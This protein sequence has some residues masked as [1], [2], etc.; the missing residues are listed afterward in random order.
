MNINLLHLS[1]IIKMNKIY[2]KLTHYLKTK[3]LDNCSPNDI[4][5]TCWI[6]ELMILKIVNHDDYFSLPIFFFRA[7]KLKKG[8]DMETISQPFFENNFW[9][10]CLNSWAF[11]EE[12]H[13]MNPAA[14][15]GIAP[16]AYG[17]GINSTKRY[18][19]TALVIS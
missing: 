10:A 1:D 3:I 2:F 16:I 17:Y 19:R 15:C 4:K 7:S 12:F 18:Y 11:K 9:K 13:G 6:G 8:F 5:T 14:N